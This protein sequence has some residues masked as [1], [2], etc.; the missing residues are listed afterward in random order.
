MKERSGVC[1]AWKVLLLVG[2]CALLLL[3]SGA[4]VFLLVRQ[5]ELTEELVRLEAQMQELSQSCRLQAGVLNQDPAEAR[6][7]RKL[8]RS[9][10]HQEEDLTQEEK[11]MMMRMAYSM[12]PV[13]ALMDLCNGSRGVCSTGPP[14]PKGLPGRAGSAGQQG[15]PGLEGRRG[16]R[17]RPGEKGECRTK[18]D[19]GPPPT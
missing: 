16:R 14:G 2:L 15:V 12:V 11:D 3:S 1:L 19:P 4:L 6:E 7:L 5:K 17:G 10:R 13:E 9:R 8:Q 18:G